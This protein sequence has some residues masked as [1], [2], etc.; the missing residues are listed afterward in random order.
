MLAPYSH[1]VELV[2]PA[3]KPIDWASIDVNHAT[4]LAHCI[5]GLVSRSRDAGKRAIDVRKEYFTVL[6]SSAPLRDL[7]CRRAHDRWLTLG[8]AAVE[9]M[10][11]A[12][13]AVVTLG[14]HFSP[15]DTPVPAFGRLSGTSAAVTLLA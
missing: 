5:P 1:E 7:C 13:V 12:P 15:Q 9:P 14:K 3:R 8:V 10:R 6:N 11:V 4:S 2:Y